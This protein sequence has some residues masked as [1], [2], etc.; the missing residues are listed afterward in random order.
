MVETVGAYS[1]GGI[2]NIGNGEISIGKFCSISKHVSFISVG[3]NTDWIST[4][5]FSSRE[6]RSE[7]TKCP[8]GIKSITGHPKRLGKL[9]VENDVWIGRGVTFI[10]NLTVGNGSVIGAFSV[11]RRNIKPYSI[12]IGNPAF[13][14][15]YRFSD[16]VIGKLL[17][18]KWWDWPKD[19]IEQNVHLLCD[20]NV[21]E[22]LKRHAIS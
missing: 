3:H 2:L 16:E 18:I 9:T 17:Q 19:K 7:W 15:G 4:Y 22:F 5:P 10:G 11:V 21:E 12:V 8:G 20:G 14:V 1:Y 13:V 6:K